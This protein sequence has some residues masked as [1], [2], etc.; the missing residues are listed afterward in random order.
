[1]P[2]MR[3]RVRWPDGRLEDCYSP[4]TIITQHLEPGVPYPLAEF[5]AKARADLTAA[6]ERVRGRFGMGCA[7]AINQMLAIEEAAGAF[8]DL[9]GA[10]VS[11]ESFQP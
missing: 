10:R 8:A 1:M 9:P 5:V 7:Q 2:E 3:F 11:V 4:L 6:N